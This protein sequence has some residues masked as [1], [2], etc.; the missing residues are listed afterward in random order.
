V[1]CGDGNRRRGKRGDGGGIASRE[2]LRLV[3]TEV[4]LVY[5]ASECQNQNLADFKPPCAMKKDPVSD[6]CRDR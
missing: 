6:G 3:G 5:K 1:D 4:P 2:R